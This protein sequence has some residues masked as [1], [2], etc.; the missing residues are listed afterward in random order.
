MANLTNITAGPTTDPVERRRE[1]ER[2]NQAAELAARLGISSITDLI[3]P[4]TGRVDPS[5]AGLNL[6]DI[7]L[8]THPDFQIGTGANGQLTGE[9]VPGSGQQAG[10]PDEIQRLLAQLGQSAGGARGG[11]LDGGAARP[12]LSGDTGSGA[13]ARQR[14]GVGGGTAPL[15]VGGSGSRPGAG[16]AAA[17]V[18]YANRQ[19]AMTAAQQAQQAR[20]PI[21]REEGTSSSTFRPVQ[22]PA[23][24][25]TAANVGGQT[26]LASQQL[27]DLARQRAEAQLLQEQLVQTPNQVAQGVFEGLLNAGGTPQSQA[28]SDRR[29]VGADALLETLAQLGNLAANPINNEIVQGITRGFQEGQL[30]DIA[31]TAESGGSSGNALRGLLEND[32]NTRLQ[33]ALAQQAINTTLGAATGQAQIGGALQPLTATDPVSTELVNLLGL[34]NQFQDFANITDL[35]GPGSSTRRRRGAGF[36]G[37]STASIG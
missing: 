2:A 8:A 11:S 17:A 15:T 28:N 9:I 4:R 21:V 32:A 24:M 16:T 37:G 25:N 13:A 1:I 12:V 20:V 19:T 29:G 23:N 14:A 18:D 6:Y 33:E 30:A 10:V 34:S 36:G 27:L 35:L 26:N 5:A 7:G 3:D 22:D 31:R